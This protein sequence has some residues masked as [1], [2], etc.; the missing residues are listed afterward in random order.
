VTGDLDK[1]TLDRLG[2]GRANATT[3]SGAAQDTG[4]GLSK[5][6]PKGGPTGPA[7]G[8]WQDRPGD[9]ASR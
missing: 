9:A 1:P 6:V 4:S 2:G 8:A 3:S 7:H 5:W